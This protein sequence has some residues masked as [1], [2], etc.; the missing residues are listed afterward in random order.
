[1]TK[2]RLVYEA[3]RARILDGTFGPGYRIVIDAV[4]KELG[5]SA[6]PVREAVRQLEAEGWLT[7]EPNVGARVNP[8]DASQYEQTLMAVALLEGEATALAAPRLRA[9]DQ[10][11]ARRLNAAM[12]AAAE[13]QNPLLYTRLNLDFHATLVA[14]CENR[15]LLVLLGHANDRLQ[16]TR[17][18]LLML[19]PRPAIAEHETLL[20]MIASGAAEGE[21]ES[22]AR[23]HKLRT[24]DAF[25]R[26]MA[27]V[28]EPLLPT[29]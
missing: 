29:A 15:Y 14:P 3:L 17:R 1:M 25:R 27:R 5:V 19:E 4:A 18:S 20:E 28:D 8:L 16:A 10:D 23:R 24:L 2:H 26:A 22:F 7:Y 12:E 6:M 13:D 21:I 9:P 11:R